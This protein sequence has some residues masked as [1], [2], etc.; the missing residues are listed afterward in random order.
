MARYSRISEKEREE[1]LNEFCDALAV[2]KG[3]KEIKEFLVDLLTSQ[4]RV[5]L[6]KRIKVAKLLLE[7]KN[8]REIEKELKVSHATIAKIAFWLLEGGKGFK[9][10]AQR[11]KKS[12]N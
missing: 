7:K 6:A 12:K 10:M 11:V 1:L 4:E 9:K 5:M 3:P 2:L 8:Y